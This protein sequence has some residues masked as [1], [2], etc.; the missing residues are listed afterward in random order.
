MSTYDLNACTTGATKEYLLLHSQT[1]QAVNE[2]L[3]TLV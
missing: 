1:V 3:V 2:E